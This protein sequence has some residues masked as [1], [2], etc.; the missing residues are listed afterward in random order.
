[1]KKFVLAAIA[2][3]TLAANAAMA[4]DLPVKAQPLPPPPAPVATWTGWYVGVGGGYGIA[5]LD[6]STT[7]AAGPPIF[8][9]GH[10]NRSK[11]YFGSVG[12]GCAFQVSQ[13]WVIG[14]FG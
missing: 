1:M 13:R 2:V 4:A 9:L 12:V 14:A 6:H 5:N 3:A 11:G 8:D 10:D 7:H